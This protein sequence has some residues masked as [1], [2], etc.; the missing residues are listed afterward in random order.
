MLQHAAANNARLL[1]VYPK[2]FR[3]DATHTPHITLVQ[4]FVHTSDLD[5]VYAALGKVFAKD[6]VGALKL[7]AFKYYYIPTG[8]TGLAGI[9]ARPSP[10]LLKVAT[11]CN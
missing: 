1:K 6:N 11:G 10:E 3:L 4:R 2:G 9:V 8:A 7:E 5:A